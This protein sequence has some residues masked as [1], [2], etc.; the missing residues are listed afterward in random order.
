MSDPTDWKA[1]FEKMRDI[2]NQY[3]ARERKAIETAESILRP[4]LAD[5]AAIYGIQPDHRFRE[6]HGLPLRLMEAI[7]E[8]LQRQHTLGA[9]AQRKWDAEHAHEQKGNAG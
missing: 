6:M 5:T 3:R 1:E 8:A 7:A 4:F 2:V 9:E